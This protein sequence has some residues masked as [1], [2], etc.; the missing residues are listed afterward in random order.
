MTAAPSQPKNWVEPLVH[1]V[2]LGVITGAIAGA[3]LTESFIEEER[4][5]VQS[6]LQPGWRYNNPQ[7]TPYDLAIGGSIG[8]LAGTLAGG[9]LLRFTKG[10]FWVIILPSSIGIAALVGNVAGFA[11]PGVGLS[12]QRREMFA[13]GGCVGGVVG[14]FL[15]LVLFVW[16]TWTTWP[17]EPIGGGTDPASQAEH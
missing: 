14:S 10:H 11:L 17:A 5:E 2:L 1:A 15:A 16:A 9:L 12:S 7:R 8:A 6:R 4:R 13:S 3:L